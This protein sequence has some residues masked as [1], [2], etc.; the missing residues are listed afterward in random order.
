MIAYEFPPSA[1]GG[2]ARISKF[3]SYLPGRGWQPVVITAEPIEGRPRDDTLVEC[4]AGIEVV[5]LPARNIITALSRLMRPARRVARGSGTGRGSGAPVTAPTGVRSPL[6]TRIAR[7]VAVPDEAEL[8]AR[9]VPRAAERLHREAPFDAVLASGPPFSA[10]VAAERIGRRLGV[11]VVSDMRDVWRDNVGVRWPTPLHRRFS[12][13]LQRTVMFAS[14]AV[15]AASPGIATEAREMGAVRV[16]TIPNGFDPAEMPSRRPDPY[17]P[18][19][20]AFL[21]RFS[22][23]V[24]DPTPFFEAFA[25][26]RSGG[27]AAATA[28][29]DIVGPSAPWVGDLVERLGLAGAVKYRGFLPYREALEVVAR[30]DVGL[31]TVAD[32]PGS[33]QLFPG[34][35]YDYMGVGIPM[36]LVGPADGGAAA[37]VRE[38]RFGAVASHGDVD[39]IVRAIEGL[40]DAKAHGRP[41]ADPDHEVVSRY[42]RLEQVGCLARLLDEVTTR[43]R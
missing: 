17:G 31:M 33:E 22:L 3:A 43:S 9:S 2:V 27:S 20:I 5:R 7:W 36:L 10:L 23:D 30:A 13:Y 16:E 24:M 6:S 8:W 21:G 26:A 4:V 37:L 19:R 12:R 25:K 35:L 14:A 32:R 41:L 34:K 38:G 11:P 18:L 15:T 42:D 28:M 39:S 29:L 40:A 1:G